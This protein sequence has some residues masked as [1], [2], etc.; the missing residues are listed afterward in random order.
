MALRFF[1]LCLALGAVFASGPCAAKPDENAGGLRLRARDSRSGLAVEAE[2]QDALKGDVI[3]TS[4][5]EAAAVL[6]RDAGRRLLE[7]RADG[8]RPLRTQLE[9]GVGER[10][11]LTVW[12]DPVGP[13]A[14]AVP[15]VRPGQALVYGVVFDATSGRPLADVR[16]RLERTSAETLSDGAGA[17]ALE[18]PAPVTDPLLELPEADVLLASRPGFM[19]TRVIEVLL[20]EGA[21]RLA[22]GMLPGEGTRVQG[23][24]HKLRRG[25]RELA[26]AQQP[27]PAAEARAGAPP[28]GMAARA[29]PDSIRVGFD[30]SCASCGS[31][32]VFSLESYVR[33]G[34]DDEWIASWHEEALRAGAIAY[35]SYG[36]WHVLHPRAPSYDICSTTCCQVIDPQ[37][38]STRVDAAV[39]F[40]AGQAVVDA[41]GEPFLAEYSAENNDGVCPDGFTGR[42][43]H[44]WP[45][46]A[47]PVDAGTSFRG[48]GRGMCQ[49]GT[50]RW[51]TGTG[52][53]H[54]WLVD[55]YY[56]DNGNPSGKRSG[57]L[58]VPRGDFSVDV[59][60][61]ALRVKRKGTAAFEVWLT[62][63]DG[64]DGPV[65]LSVTGVPSGASARLSLTVI[66]T[67]GM[68]VLTVGTTKKTAT[69]SFRLTLTAASGGLARAGSA[70]L[71]VTK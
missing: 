52:R 63:R 5:G 58:L 4:R 11:E 35:R 2:V 67:S 64:F 14:R 20:T 56:N 19:T 59:Q 65:E 9:P 66:R 48:H 17:F 8:Y 23:E 50:Q 7:V 32:Q 6:T 68:S 25:A 41:A 10:L 71:T 29:L 61:A 47:D 43:E 18:V 33:L 51:A 60:P 3:A 22:I 28:P 12:L 49:W 26:A 55:H 30:C 15:A 36:A 70:L 38:S 45:C 16:V 34:L 42:P 24:A 40:T 31:V 13:E 1:R 44:D 69:G 46:L 39:A 62:P 27:P 53:E 54:P 37:D 57:L 21:T